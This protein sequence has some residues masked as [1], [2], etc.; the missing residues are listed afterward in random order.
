MKVQLHYGDSF[1]GLDIPDT[2]IRQIIRPWSGD[3]EVGQASMLNEATACIH[4]AGFQNIIAGK[5]LGV[6]VPDG[7]RKLFLESVFAQVMPTLKKASPARF[8]ICTGTHNP[9][10]P[11]NYTIVEQITDTAADAGLDDFEIHIHDC[12]KDDF[13]RAGKTT[14]ATDVLYNAKIAE[15]DIFLILS[16]VKVHYFA[17]YS[18]PIK[19]LVPGLCAFRTIEHNHSLA[20]DERST[21]G[22]HPWH[23][24]PAR[25]D[26]PLAADQLEAMS[27]IVKDRP[28]YSLVT[29][30]DSGRIRW[31]RFGAARDVTAEAFDVVDEK[32]THTTEAIDRLIVSSGGLPNDID[33]YIA[34]RALELTK[35]PLADGGEVLFLAACPRGIGEEHTMEN[36]Y[37]R[38]TQPID[39]ILKSIEAE[40]EMFS[41]KPYKLARMLKSLRRIW[42]HTQIP[43]DLIEAAHLWPAHNP[44]KVVDTWLAENPDT[45][46]TI[47]DGANK[48][49]LYAK[50]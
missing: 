34:Q 5:R 24:N 33:F 40:Y 10:T 18:N 41:H 37:N 6:L 3:K 29:I 38:L 31:S 17:G 8:F 25:R 30:S 44:Q 22:L 27:M 16:D 42:M 23:N 48:I 47:V 46:I 9:D 15:N 4:T 11:E 21:F 26:N 13:L 1:V 7:T 45:K 35:Q 39:K 14:L 32:N 2:N 20:L 43:D 50:K 28:V 49:A 19:N 12:Q 36:F